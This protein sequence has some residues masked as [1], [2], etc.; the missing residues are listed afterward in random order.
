L[1]DSDRPVEGRPYRED[2]T[3]GL[4]AVPAHGLMARMTT[5][6]GTVA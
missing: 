6:S 5:G 1:Y 3:A 4:D 2:A